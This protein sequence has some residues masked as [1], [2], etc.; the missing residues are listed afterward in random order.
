MITV[1][2]SKTPFIVSKPGH[3]RN[4]QVDNVIV[5]QQLVGSQIHLYI[6][7][8]LMNENRVVN[9]VPCR[10]WSIQTAMLVPAHN[11]STKNNSPTNYIVDS[12]ASII[13][14][15][16]LF[17]I[18]LNTNNN[19]SPIHHYP[20]K[21]FSNECQLLSPFPFNNSFIKI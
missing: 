3:H 13:P 7:Y 15:H 16:Q 4:I 17:S 8:I 21:S 14:S 1:A 11:E 12:N 19:I 10:R 2:L 20:T 6:Y 9:G 5:S 18:N